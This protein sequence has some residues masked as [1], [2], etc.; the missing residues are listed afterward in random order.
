MHIVTSLKE[1]DKRRTLIEIDEENYGFLYNGEIRKLKIQSEQTLSDAILSEIDDI[2]YKRAKER[3]L[4]LIER[5]EKTTKE[6]RDKLRQGRYRQEIIDQ[7]IQF[8]EKYGFIDDMVYAKHYIE[9]KQ[10]RRSRKQITMELL[11]KGVSKDIIVET[12]EKFG[13]DEKATIQKLAYK[14][15]RHPEEL[16][17][18]QK[19]RLHQY[20]LGK[21]FSYG[22]IREALSLLDRI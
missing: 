12:F 9:F 10:A 2:Q 3:A 4:Y 17:E 20:L 13:T 19:R 15:Y 8:L 22:D 6:I 21:G 14:K 11:Q 5:S 16:D 1:L 18:V 7:V